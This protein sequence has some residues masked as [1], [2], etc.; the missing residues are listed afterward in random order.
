MYLFYLGGLLLPVTPSAVEF[1]DKNN[2][3]VLSLIDGSEV[4]MPEMPG[5]CEIRFSVLLPMCE[6]P[7]SVYEGGFKDGLFFAKAL[8]G[9]K[10]EAKPLWFRVLRYGG[11]ASTDIACVIDELSFNEEALNG[12][13]ITCEIVLRQYAD[14]ATRVIENNGSAK[15]AALSS[16]RSVPQSV[17]IGEG[18][19]LWTIARRCYGDGARYMELYGKNEQ[20]IESAARA[21]GLAC[22]ESGR[23]IF[24]GETLIL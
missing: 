11:R 4:S 24:A 21:H 9:M 2:N 1:K 22:S 12:G 20:A 23:Y 16:E 18:D 10:A 5:L 19:T 13:D 14:Y 8:R 7:F 3:R 17:V 6:Y 15:A